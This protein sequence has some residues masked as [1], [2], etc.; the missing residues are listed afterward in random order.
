MGHNMKCCIPRR[1][2]SKYLSAAA[3]AAAGSFSQLAIGTQA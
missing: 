2:L 1:V 3:A